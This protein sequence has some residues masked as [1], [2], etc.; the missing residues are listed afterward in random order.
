M[1]RYSLHLFL[2]G[3]RTRNWSMLNA[4]FEMT[5]PPFSLAFAAAFAALGLGLLVSAPI[6]AGLGAI[7]VCAQLL[8]TLRGL[9]IMPVQSPRIYLAL[10]YAPLFILWK[11]RIYLGLALGNR[12]REWV[13]TP[14]TEAD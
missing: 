11:A 13:R 5:I 12:S 1:V 8:Y 2:T 10:V 3:V 4:A 9:A 6:A 14:R 7:S